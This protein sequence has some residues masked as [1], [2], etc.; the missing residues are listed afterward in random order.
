MGRAVHAHAHPRLREGS[1]TVPLHTS[2]RHNLQ[3]PS[4][5][6]VGRMDEL[7]EVHRRLAS[8]HPQALISITG[9]PTIGKSALAHAAAWM[10]TEEWADLSYS[11]VAW[12]AAP[13]GPHWASGA[14]QGLASLPY[15]ERIAR[16][17]RSVVARP[18][19][20]NGAA[21][22]PAGLT[23][24]R[25]IDRAHDSLLVPGGV[26]LLLDAV[27]GLDGDEVDELRELVRYLPDGC[28]A[29]AT[30]GRDLQFG[31]PIRLSPLPDGDMEIVIAQM[32]QRLGVQLDADLG[33]CLRTWS[34]GF[35]RVAERII[36]EIVRYGP[37]RARSR[38][39]AP[40]AEWVLDL[41]A[42]VF[43]TTI[44]KLHADERSS[45]GALLDL[46]HSQL[47]GDIC[48]G[49][50]A[51]ALAAVLNRNARHSDGMLQPLLASNLLARLPSQTLYSML[52]ITRTYLR[53]AQSRGVL[54]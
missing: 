47:D 13:S 22:T 50:T 6:F 28:K 53:C 12:I 42:D 3:G 27:D 52:P 24:V 10:V 17:V 31:F 40:E 49:M 9:L 20:A 54:P 4:N 45:Y 34:H 16:V 30:M 14:P 48:Q 19:G 39:D 51:A 36:G 33:H 44:R 29:I 11:T 18:A 7:E 41:F 21:P 32:R 1:V 2:V 43:A 8:A 37:D 46:A 26:L 15:L 5:P 23:R 25:R 35:A 38:Q